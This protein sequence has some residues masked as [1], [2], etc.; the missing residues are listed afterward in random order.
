MTGF[1]MA[2][3]ALLWLIS[4]LNVRL[5]RSLTEKK[6][7]PRWLA[8]GYGLMTVMATLCVMPG[9]L[10]HPQVP[11]GG[12]ALNVAACAA[13]I[14]LAAQ[15][16]LLPLLAVGVSLA[17]ALTQL[18]RRRRFGRRIF[19]KALCGAPL[20]ALGISGSGVYEAQ[21][22]MTVERLT[23]PFAKLPVEF[24]GFVIAQLSDAHVGPFF[25]LERL[26][27]A[28]KRIA[29]AK[30]D[31][32]VITGDL[33]NEAA[34]LDDS[35]E[36]ICAIARQIPHGAYF[37]WGNHEY[38]HDVSKIR[39]ALERSNIRLL[40]NHQQILT[41]GGATLH[42]IGVDYPWARK[43]ESAAL[44]RRFLDHATADIPDGAFRVLLAHHPDFISEAFEDRI[45]LTL[46]GHTHG[47]QVKLFGRYWFNFGYRYLAGLYREDGCFGYVHTGTG[48]W[49]PLRLN[50]PPQVSLLTLQRVHS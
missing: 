29:S 12:E 23:L 49:L 36:L 9:W 39:T 21:R 18:D 5:L 27:E 45:E 37:C 6:K 44:R 8:W 40:D 30:P 19:L 48:H 20:L 35:L 10:A 3:M 4:A 42:L 1:R 22:T 32:L 24:D 38:Y 16:F 33:I 28:L 25:S 47:G 50:C 17:A 7:L 26:A 14:W 41:V 34:L 31:L 13:V 46:T 15:L 43:E 11:L 2:A